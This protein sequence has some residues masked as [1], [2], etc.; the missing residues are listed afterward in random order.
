VH[1]LLTETLGSL[2][3]EDE[4]PESVLV[5]IGRNLPKQDIL[6]ALDSCLVKL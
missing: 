6:A 5:F 3:Q 2:W 4:T 1:M